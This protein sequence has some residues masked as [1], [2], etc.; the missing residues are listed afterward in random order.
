[1]ENLDILIAQYKNI[2]EKLNSIS[3]ELS[4]LSTDTALNK[5][6][7][8][9]LKQRLSTLE[10]Q[11]ASLHNE[12]EAMKDS[13]GDNANSV[14]IEK[15]RKWDTV[16]SSILKNMLPYVISLTVAG[17]TLKIKGVV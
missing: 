3:K 10:M 4:G 17:I 15:S 2:D 6:D 9:Y 12:I 1:M 16:V 11:Q 7:I 14:T 13:I 8:L 5:N